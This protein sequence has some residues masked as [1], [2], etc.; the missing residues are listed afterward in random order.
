MRPLNVFAISTLGY[1]FVIFP[2]INTDLENVQ[3][4]ISMLCLNSEYTN[5]P[6]GNGGKSVVDVQNNTTPSQVIGLLQQF[7]DLYLSNR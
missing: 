3:R 1:S 2:R 7:V 5:L 6:R 4:Q